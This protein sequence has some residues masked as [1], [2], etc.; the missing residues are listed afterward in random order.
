MF[1][2]RSQCLYAGK[3]LHCCLYSLTANCYHAVASSMFPFQMN[4]LYLK[5]VNIDLKTNKTHTDAL[6]CVK[7]KLNNSVF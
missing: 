5:E 1:K 4:T 2:L 7:I 6:V 3:F